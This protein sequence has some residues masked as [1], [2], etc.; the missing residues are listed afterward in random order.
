MINSILASLIPV[1][2]VMVLG[3]VA[4][5][6]KDIDNR[7][8]G[9]LNALVMDFALPAALFTAMAQTPRAA[10][11][12]QA[13]LA[14]VLLIAM[15]IVFALALAIQTRLYG[16][17]QQESALLALTSSGPN[18]GSAGLPMIAALFSQSAS[19]S[20]AVAVAV[21]AVVVTPISLML[22]EAACGSGRGSITVLRSALLKPLVIAPVCGLLMSLGGLSLP[23][24]LDSALALVGQ[25]ASG[26]SLFLTGLVLSAQSFRF[27]ASIGL[28]VAMK[29]VLQPLLAGALAILL[30]DSE[31]ARVAV[32]LT[33]VP[34][35]A[36][37]VLLAIRYGVPSV[38][39][40][41]TLIASTISSIITL[42][43]SII[44]SEQIWG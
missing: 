43:A 22:V 38:Q 37:G 33:A 20:V 5:L 15:L 11:I 7:N 41:T 24:T 42:G 36:F 4:G 1:F 27:N 21:A 9:S 14:L 26:A 39:I 3:F 10:L 17:G 18:V 2:L 12:G 25:G 44:L 35:G 28:G 30:L 40:G 13:H 23:S 29:N 19:V 32:V 31:E 16:T 6:T 34:S 8:I